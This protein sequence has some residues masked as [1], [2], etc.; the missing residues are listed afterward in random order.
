MTTTKHLTPE[1]IQKRPAGLWR[2]REF[3][4][5]RKKESIVSLGEIQTP[6]IPLSDRCKQ[7]NHSGPLLVKD[8]SRLPTGSF[9]A[10]GISVAISMAKELGISSVAMPTNGNAG[11]ALAAYANRAGIPCYL[12]C[13]QTNTPIIN[14][15]EM[16]IAA[17]KTPSSSSSHV[18]KVGP[19]NAYIHDCGK[20]VREGVPKLGW[21]DMSTLKEPYRIEGKK[22]MGLELVDQFGWKKHSLPNVI[23]YPTGG[24]TGLIGMW[25]AFR[26][27]QSIGWIDSDNDDDSSTWLPRMVVVQDASCAP[28]VRAWEQG[29][30]SDIE[31]WTTPE[32][33]ENCLAAGIRVPVVLGDALVLQVLTESNGFAMAVSGSEI[34]Q[35]IQTV[36]HHEGLLFCPEGAATYAAYQKSVQEQR[37]Q[38]DDTVVLFNCANGIKYDTSH[39][40][41]PPTTISI[42]PS[43]SSASPVIDYEQLRST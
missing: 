38:P 2:Y 32:N 12:F 6:L 29:K 30:T 20:I 3:L 33:E 17:S 22:T 27:L 8:E 23:F 21:F 28:I 36:A 10:R 19:R 26:E 7:G 41:P 42:Q 15:R 34:E 13:P 18:W 4:P 40:F 11:A 9:K 5:V 31:P 24:G 37:I 39:L 16:Q 25:K 35:A 43:S 14:V 1:E